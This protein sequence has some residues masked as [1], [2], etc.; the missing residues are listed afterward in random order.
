MLLCICAFV[1]ARTHASLYFDLGPS[2]QCIVSGFELVFGADG[3]HSLANE[4]GTRG[5]L[6]VW[7]ILLLSFECVLFDHVCV[8]DVW[9]CVCVSVCI[10]VCVCVFV[11]VFVCVCVCVVYVI[12]FASA[13]YVNVCCTH[14]HL[15]RIR[16]IECFSRMIPTTT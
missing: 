11:C 6:R 9:L 13:A 7:G 1:C 4:F 14:H 2:W 12:A 15:R 8:W 3:G 5:S 16:F 10:C